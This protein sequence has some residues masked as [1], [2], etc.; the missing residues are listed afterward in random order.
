ML[1]FTP[2]C[3]LP[4][5]NAMPSSRP[6]S[7]FALFLCFLSAPRSCLCPPRVASPVAFWPAFLARA[8]LFPAVGM[9][10]RGRY[11]TRNGPDARSLRPVAYRALRVFSKVSRQSPRYLW[12]VGPLSP[13]WRFPLSVA[14]DSAPFCT[15]RLFA[16]PNCQ[17]RPFVTPFRALACGLCRPCR[18]PTPYSPWFS[19]DLLFW[20]LL[21]SIAST[22]SHAHGRLAT[23]SLALSAI[24][25]L[26]F[27]TASCHSACSLSTLANA[28]GQLV[29]GCTGLGPPA[30]SVDFAPVCRNLL[31]PLPVC[32]MGTTVLPPVVY[33]LPRDTHTTWR[34]CCDT[35]LSA[36][37]RPSSPHHSHRRHHCL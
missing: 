34:P 6:R 16:L 27:A 25:L 32:S 12:A 36:L 19:A 24:L 22:N 5:L 9:P 29:S 17:G 10:F 31:A 26:P 35:F 3:G 28:P 2:A 21:H 8:L 13:A 37:V 4:S 18:V 33:A 14:S 15:C 7:P 1:V 23:C 11:C 30:A 20:V